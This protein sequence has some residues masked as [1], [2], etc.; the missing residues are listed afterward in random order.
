MTFQNQKLIRR[1]IT[2][3]EL[4]AIHVEALKENESGKG[5]W[6][7]THIAECPICGRGD[8][9]K[10]RKYGN[11]PETVWDQYEYTIAYDYCDAL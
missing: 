11:R 1:D 9:I 10:E 5:C 6:Y 3:E 4:N 8:T 7:L 2:T